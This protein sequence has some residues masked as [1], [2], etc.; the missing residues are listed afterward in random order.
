[1]APSL[2]IFGDFT[3]DASAMYNNF[4]VYGTGLL[5][6]MGTIVFIGVKFVNKFATVALACVLLSILA[7]YVGIFVNFNGNDKLQLVLLLNT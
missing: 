3:K 4:R 5:L 2:S 7:V 1:M 6:V